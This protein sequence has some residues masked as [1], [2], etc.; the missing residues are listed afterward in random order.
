MCIALILGKIL[1]HYAHRVSGNIHPWKLK[2]A[3]C[4][5]SYVLGNK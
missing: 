2:C 1:F 4:T 3:W 5:G